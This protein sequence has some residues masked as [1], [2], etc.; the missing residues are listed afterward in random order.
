MTATHLADKSVLAR[1][2][3]QVV[4]RRVG[5]MLVEGM[6]ATCP[7]IDLEVL[8]SARS[9]AD[10]PAILVERRSMPTFVSD[11]QVTGQECQWVMPPGSI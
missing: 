6:I 10:H 5:P 9:A 8:H 2:H 4:F 11:E 3:R 7:I 1:L